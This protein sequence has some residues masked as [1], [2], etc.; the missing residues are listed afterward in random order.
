LALT[1]TT[2]PEGILSIKLHHRAVSLVT[3]YFIG[4]YIEGNAG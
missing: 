4:N 2:E 1:A 3:L